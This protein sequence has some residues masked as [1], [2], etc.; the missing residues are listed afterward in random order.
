MLRERFEFAFQ[1][2]GAKVCIDLGRHPDVGVAGDAGHAGD[3]GAALDEPGAAGP[4]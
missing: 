3:V 4:A 1:I 2:F